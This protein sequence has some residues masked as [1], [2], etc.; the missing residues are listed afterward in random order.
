MP[1]PFQGK[2]ALSEPASGGFQASAYFRMGP[3][4][5]DPPTDVPSRHNDVNCRVVRTRE[6]REAVRFRPPYLEQT[7]ERMTSRF[8]RRGE[9]GRGGGGESPVLSRAQLR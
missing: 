7:A 3:L 1:S 4:S 8:Q 6:D 2:H 5:P 9:Q